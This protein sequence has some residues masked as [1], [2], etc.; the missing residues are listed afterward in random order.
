L[1]EEE[2]EIDKEIFVLTRS[3]QENFFFSST[4]SD[5]EFKKKKKILS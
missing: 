5:Q 1:G 3:D 2:I 4:R